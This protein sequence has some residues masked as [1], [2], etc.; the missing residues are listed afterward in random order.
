MMPAS[1]QQFLE[2]R[3]APLGASS[4]SCRGI[5]SSNYLLKHFA[6]QP[7]YPTKAAVGQLYNEVEQ[8]WQ[9]NVGGLRA[10]GEAYTRTHFLDPLLTALG[11]EFIPESKM[12]KPP[13]GTRKNR[14]DYC[15]FPDA[16]SRQLAAQQTDTAGLYTFS[17]T[18][19]EA[20]RWQHSLDR[21]S[22]KETPGRFPSE[23]IQGYLHDAK[24][25]SGKRY[26][27][28]AILT[29]GCDWRLYCEQAGSG[30]HF[31][32]TLVDQESFCTLEQ[33]RLFVA[34]FRSSAFSRDSPG[35]C[36]LDRLREESLTRQI[37]LEYNLRQRIFDVLEDLANAF[38]DHKPNG[39]K[40]ELFGA[41]YDN[42][43]IFLYRL[44]FV[45][46]AESRDL[47]PAKLHGPGANKT[48]R[49]HFS[50]AR[51]VEDLRSPASYNSDAFFTLYERLL[52]LF[53]LINGDNPKQ[54]EETRVT[55]YNGG[56]F[57]HALHPLLETW[58][59]PDRWLVKVL[60]QLVFAQ[61]PAR[62]G[63]KQQ[64]IVTEDAIDYAS[65]EVRQLGDIYEGLL[66]AKLD[67]NETRRLELQDE[68]GENH[69]H[70]IYYT[71]DWIVRYLLRE[72]LRPLLADIE[73]QPDVQAALAG[74]S[75]ESRQNNSFARAVLGLNLLDPAMG[76]GH[77]LV[78]A[79]EELARVIRAHPTTRLM[80]MQVVKQGKDRRTKED[81]RKLSFVPVPEG[82]SQENAEMAYWRRR[83]VEACIYGVDLNPLAVELAKLSLWLTCIAAD[84]PLNF[85]DHHLRAGN[86]LVF[87]Q[88]DELSHSPLATA[89]QRKEPPVFA[90]DELPRALAAV[91]RE[92]MDIEQ[93]A[94]TEMELVKQ[95]EE[96]W[97]AVRS[98]LAPFL[99]VAHLWLAA[100]DGAPVDELSY[101]LLVRAA[102]APS[103]LD[104]KEKT[105]ARKLQESLA[106]ILA[107]KRKTL[108]AFHWQLEFPDV[109]YLP[110][111]SPRPEAERGFDAILGNPPYIRRHVFVNELWSQCL[112]KR[113]GDHYDIYVYFAE[114]GFDLLR[115]GGGFGFITSD[116][117]FTLD[118]LLDMRE[119]LQG[120]ELTHLGQC[121][122]FDTV[123]VDAAIFVARKAASA[124]AAPVSGETAGLLFIQAYPRK[125]FSGEARDLERALDTLPPADKIPFASST[126][127]A[128]GV[129]VVEHG[130]HG[131]QD[132][133]RVHRVPLALYRCAHK[134]AFF[135]TR[136]GTLRLFD[137]YNEPVKQLVGEWW[138]RIE[139]SRAFEKHLADIGAYQA[140]L[141]SGDITLVGLVA[142]GGQGMRTA[143]NARFL[144]YLEG[145]PQAEIL[146]G[147][148]E[149]WTARWLADVRIKSVFLELL[150]Q[151]GGDPAKPIRDGAAWEASCE[152]LR[153]QFTDAQ[154]GIGR[155]DLYR[156]APKSLVADDSDFE[157]AWK[158]RK[159]E[160]LA[161][162]QNEKALAEFASPGTH[163]SKQR[164]QARRLFKAK[165]VSDAEFCLL[166][167]ELQKW[168]AEENAART[169]QR[170]PTIPR[171]AIG[172]RSS[173]DYSDPT[174]A[175]RIAT[176]YNGL[177]GRGRF[178][179]YRKGDP[180]GNRWLD[181][182]PLFIDWVR[183]NVI[184][185]F[186]N[187]GKPE[188]RM[189]V[190]RNV[191]LYF[192]AGVTYTLHANHVPIKARYQQ[193]CVFDAGGSR[194]TPPK[195][196]LNAEAF[197]AILNSD[198]FSFFLK[199]FVK[200]NQDVEINDLRQMPLIMPTKA[201]AKRLDSLAELAIETKR[202]EFSGQQPSHALA[203]QVRA[204]AE[205]L[206]TGA[207]AYLKPL[208]QQQL[209]ATPASCLAVLELAVNWEA[210]KLYGVEGGGPFDEF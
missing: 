171:D 53:H 111:G 87:A 178:V 116:T 29:N 1:A 143:N 121:A 43:L 179:P 26:F 210:E 165:T 154:L 119:L 120:H 41:L 23:Q 75:D 16:P 176:I 33:F 180:T 173:E 133:L 182:E 164:Q 19:L 134:R 137:K 100:Y 78:R 45:L 174:D 109:F 22:E 193:P 144:G 38:H 77:F 130:M 13:K 125:T 21:V 15:L 28:W 158:Q 30:R 51:L 64:K 129:G 35:R 115:S 135:E 138:E 32:F 132:A 12:P 201:Q 186:A 85:L 82:L 113:R 187:S 196:L 136:P 84:E 175:P 124:S 161:H 50:I 203:S 83:V 76:S 183:T 96:R 65:L 63:A 145:T 207:P 181:D 148:R 56:L 20:K 157:F 127:P 59:I 126:E 147:K 168:V 24:D 108:N 123:T 46:Y 140:N 68:N 195:R 79:T 39:I 199:K 25:A 102:I 44:L 10:Q 105:E 34:L 9:G 99:D 198:V 14:P 57:N 93:T 18:V 184:W 185:L 206:V 48:Y 89:E 71:P 106:E 153:S 151:N 61:P 194:L 98:K 88:P 177:S 163:D 73:A 107:S 190:I 3:D 155:M 191:D 128:C 58:R 189:P 197:L 72:T 67:F 55:R 103:D 159:A 152:E 149:G 94:S 4:F 156:I 117:Y 8:L 92:N 90:K 205:E 150:V 188:T 202:S 49:E 36:L 69:R 17:E 47:L 170:V 37:E 142:E 7:G 11:W 162:W 74:K 40:P 101:R 5:F 192:T 95:K 80:T 54:N 122:P 141:K 167:Q 42:S 52:K 81:I 110:D 97:K 208:A 118:T 104:N 146:L 27:N 131:R 91:I 62:T 169:R 139:S 112:L 86:S 200:H 114:L 6:E 2:L 160:L 66:G 172:L 31:E 60:K 166:C 204:L 70:G 209:L